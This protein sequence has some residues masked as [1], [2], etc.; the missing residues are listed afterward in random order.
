[1]NR[2]L[3]FMKMG[4]SNVTAWSVLVVSLMNKYNN[5][6]SVMYTFFTPLVSA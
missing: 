3:N 4:V 2:D 5:W 6:N 1:M